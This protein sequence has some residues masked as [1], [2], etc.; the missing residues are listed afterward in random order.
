VC[1][2]GC[3]ESPTDVPSSA[4]PQGSPA[5]ATAPVAAA[6][7]TTEEMTLTVGYLLE[8]N[9][10]QTIKNPDAETIEKHFRAIDWQNAD[11]PGFIRLLRPGAKGPSY[12]IVKGTLG[13]PD[14]DKVFMGGAILPNAD[15]SL[16]VAAES[17]LETVDAGF[18]LLTLFQ[19]DMEKL[20]TVARQW[21]A[22]VAE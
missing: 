11:R 15:E 14:T 5:A 19:N 4:T 20:R 1:I 9:S 13:K 16:S 22:K 10:L 8:G 18:E 17:P 2:F 7:V 3:T 12:V 6:P 21:A